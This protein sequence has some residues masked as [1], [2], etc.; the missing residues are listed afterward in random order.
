MGGLGAVRQ[1][2]VERRAAAG[3]LVDPRAAAVELGE[4]RH[5]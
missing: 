3:S 5:Q 1:E 2:D 4:P